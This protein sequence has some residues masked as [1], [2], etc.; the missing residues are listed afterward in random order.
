MENYTQ[1]KALDGVSSEGFEFGV[2]Q[3]C[4]CLK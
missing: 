1:Q 4:Q 2:I 3:E